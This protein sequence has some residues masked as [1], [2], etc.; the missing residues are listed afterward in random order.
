M[1][2]ADIECEIAL[3]QDESDSKRFLEERPPEE[4]WFSRN[5]AFREQKL[6]RRR[7]HPLGRFDGPSGTSSWQPGEGAKS[8]STEH[9]SEKQ[10][11]GEENVKGS[12]LRGTGGD[13]LPR[14][15]AEPFGLS[16]FR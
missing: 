7:G 2:D 12:F 10:D 8:L 11:D 4:N 16:G 5:P 14:R 1:N 3:F 15:A 6:H 9:V 13:A